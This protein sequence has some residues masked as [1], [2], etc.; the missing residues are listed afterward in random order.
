MKNCC[1]KYN[2]GMLH[3]GFIYDYYV[4]YKNC[5]TLNRTI[6]YIISFLTTLIIFNKNVLNLLVSQE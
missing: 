5:C 4:K 6:L 2:E 1:K 3:F